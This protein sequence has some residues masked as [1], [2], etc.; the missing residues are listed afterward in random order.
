M[1]DTLKN[2][3]S[4]SSSNNIMMKSELLSGVAHALRPKKT[5]R[6]NDDVLSQMISNHHKQA[7]RIDRYRNQ[8]T[9]KAMRQACQEPR[10]SR[11]VARS[12]RSMTALDNRDTTQT[13]PVVA[14]HP[15]DQDQDLVVVAAAVA[16]AVGIDIRESTGT[17]AARRASTI[18]A[19]SIITSTRR[20][21]GVHDMR[22]KTNPTLPSAISAVARET[23]SQ[24]LDRGSCLPSMHRSVNI[25]VELLIY[26]SKS[27][28][29]RSMNW[30][31]RVSL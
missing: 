26:V 20:S 5:A 29:T 17:L 18:R 16:T 13:P 11:V 7:K 9:N 15:R 30:Q 31:L 2:G 27:N 1:P 19:P 25:C 21:I 6:A 3:S 23:T 10:C 8:T 28:Q 4:S 12:R 24:T 22:A 14:T